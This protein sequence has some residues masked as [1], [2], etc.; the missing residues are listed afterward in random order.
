MLA[1]VMNLGFAARPSGTAEFSMQGDGAAQ[2]IGVAIG[3]VLP[4]PEVVPGP[5]PGVGGAWTRESSRR[6]RRIRR[7]DEEIVEIVRHLAPE[8][9][10]RYRRLH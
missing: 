8:I 6:R 2:W 1:W 9:L 5:E 3:E 10:R 7:E 4:E